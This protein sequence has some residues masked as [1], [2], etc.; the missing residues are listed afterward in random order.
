VPHFVK[1]TTTVQGKAVVHVNL[2]EVAYLSEEWRPDGS[3]LTVTAVLKSGFEHTFH[4]GNGGE[5]FHREFL[6]Y[7]S[8]LT[9]AKPA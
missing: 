6:A 7:L 3:F 8:M 2:E 9:Q 1:I 4:A 5:E